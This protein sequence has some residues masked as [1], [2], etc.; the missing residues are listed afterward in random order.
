MLVSVG[1]AIAFG[2]VWLLTYWPSIF[3]KVWTWP[4]MIISAF[5]TLLAVTFVQI[6]LQYYINKGLGLA[7]DATTIANWYLL[8]GI[9]VVLASGLVQEAAKSIP[10]AIWWWRSGRSITPKT[11]LLIGAIAGAGFGIFEAFWV[12]GSLFAAGWTTQLISQH[13][14]DG[15]AGF[16]ERFFTVGFHI[17]VSALVGYGLARGKWWQYYLIAAGLHTIA[18]YAAIF[19]GYFGVI[20]PAAWLKTVYIEIYIAVLAVVI[21]AVAL[22]LRWHRDEDEIPPVTIE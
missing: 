14:F 1:L 17:A 20:H 22:Y 16:F 10:M 15:I 8:A 12:H 18:N 19:M 2:A 7:W 9:P 5:L 4:T 3:K 13:G 6:P 21:T 11:G